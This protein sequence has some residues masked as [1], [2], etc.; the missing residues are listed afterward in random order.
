MKLALD[1][2]WRGWGRVH[3][4]PMV[5]A[6]VLRDGD[7]AGTG[8]HAEFG[9]P[10][11]ETV[12]LAE[13][14]R[15]AQDAIL[16][17]TLEPCAHTGKQP[18]CTDAI[19]KAGISQVVFA[20]PDP[21]PEAAGGARLLE[22]AGIATSSGVM[23]ES[24]EHQNAIF[25]GATRRSERPFVALKLATSMDARIADQAGHS[26]WISGSAARD[27]VHWLRSGFDAIGVG[28]GTAL[29]DDP[30]LT[31]RGPV[32]PRI[33][34]RRL[35][36]GRAQGL[37]STLRL[38]QSPSADVVNDT[39]SSMSMVLER[40]RSDGVRSL[41]IEGGGRLAGHLLAE[42]LVDRFYHVQA[43]LWLGEGGRPAFAGLE[44]PGG[45][46]NAA[47]WK[48]RDRRALGEDTLLVLDRHGCSP[49]L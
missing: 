26:R 40:L 36:F 4:N 18:P 31:V 35:I 27:W 9:G 24:A 29:A 6:V 14:G 28:A 41:L 5:G 12:A 10:H 39:D 30:S 23:A 42:D 8:Y 47:R 34:P 11:A 25:L 38:F 33:N 46:G 16:V 3:P 15:A 1:L 13:A 48:V 20:I 43:P 44:V 45:I 21:D 22:A 37:P 2:A 7:I 17:S 19:I 32:Q 49:V